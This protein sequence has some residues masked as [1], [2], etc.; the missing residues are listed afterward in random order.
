MVEDIL[1]ETS[2]TRGDYDFY[3]LEADE[4]SYDEVEDIGRELGLEVFGE[5]QDLN[6]ETTEYLL[7]IRR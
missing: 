1:D 4:Y 2:E 6:G 3:R 5:A 7:S